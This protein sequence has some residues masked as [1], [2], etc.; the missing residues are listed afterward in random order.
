MVGA[1]EETVTFTVETE[2]VLLRFVV[3]VTTVLMERAVELPLD[4]LKVTARIAFR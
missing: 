1:A 2:A 4:V 3:S